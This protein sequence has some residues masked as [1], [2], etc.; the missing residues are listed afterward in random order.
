MLSLSRILK[1]SYLLL[2]GGVVLA[3]SK[4]APVRAQRAQ[5]A[6]QLPNPMFMQSVMM[7]RQQIMMASSG[8]GMM[9]T[10]GMM[11]MRGGMGGGMMGMGGFSGKKA[12]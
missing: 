7:A 11:G 1:I 12:L 9:G 2:L 6:P 4:P 8:G 5:M 3:M 10:G